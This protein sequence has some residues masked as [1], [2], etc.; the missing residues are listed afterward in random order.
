MDEQIKR[1]RAGTIVG[2]V[3][4]LMVV[5][6]LATAAHLLSWQPSDAVRIFLIAVGPALLLAGILV[7]RSG[8]PSGPPA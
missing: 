5:L 3:G 4:L 2:L 7:A 6:W 1:K 8:A